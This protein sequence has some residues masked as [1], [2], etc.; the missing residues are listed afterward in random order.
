MTTRRSPIE[1][2]QNVYFIFT[3]RFIFINSIK[4]LNLRVL[5]KYY[6]STKRFN[7]INIIIYLFI[8]LLFIYFFIIIYFIYFMYYC[9]LIFIS[10]NF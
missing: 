1:G 9:L 2:D 3:V 10:L 8:L 6:I 5:H 4:I 7:S